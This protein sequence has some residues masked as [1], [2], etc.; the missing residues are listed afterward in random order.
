MSKYHIP[1]SSQRV[2]YC[3]NCLCHIVELA[4]VYMPSQTQVRPICPAWETFKWVQDNTH[5]L[6]LCKLFDG[7]V[8]D[9]PEFASAHSENTNLWSKNTCISFYKLLPSL[10]GSWWHSKQDINRVLVA[11]QTGHQLIR[12]ATYHYINLSGQLLISTSTYQ[13]IKLSLHWLIRTTTFQYI[14]LS[15]QQLISTSTYQ[16]SNLSVH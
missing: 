5:L 7:L 15:G 1:S 2:K 6:Q 11:Q 3:I 12:T 4:A 10:R 16:D 13:Y 9:L 8:Q 14:N